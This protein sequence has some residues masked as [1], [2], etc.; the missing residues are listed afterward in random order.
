VEGEEMIEVRKL[1]VNLGDFSLEDIDLSVGDGEYLVIMGPTGAGK[2]LL[3]QTILGFIEPEEGKIIVDGRDVTK[4]PPEMRNLSYVPQEYA[5]FPHM[6]VFDNIAFG[7]KVRG[8]SSSEVR[9]RVGEISEILR[10]SHL[11][12]RKPITLSGGE[13]QR[14]ALARALVIEP[15]A[16]LMDEPLSAIHRSLREELQAFLKEIHSKLGFTAIHV[17]HDHLEASYLGDRIALIVGGRIIKVGS[18]EE[19]RDDPGASEFMGPENILRGRAERRENF[20]VIRVNSIDLIS[21]YES[22]GDVLVI[23][24]PEDI[25]IHPLG[26]L[27]KTSA[28]NLLEA[29]VIAVKYRPPVYEVSLEASGVKLRSFLTKQALEELDVREGRRVLISMKASALKILPYMGRF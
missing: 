16:V 25:F 20:T 13:R 21:A 11:L 27:P 9:E 26:E 4:L 24:R 28:R 22:E 2:T 29:E 15:K 10:I 6:S 14:V 7:L 1:S 8:K 19:L 18:L 5:L 23:V 3:L 12:E 17:T